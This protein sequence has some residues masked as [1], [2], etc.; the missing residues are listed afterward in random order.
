MAEVL[1]S[2][3]S[4]FA[5]EA[6]AKAGSRPPLVP[7]NGTLFTWLLLPNLLKISDIDICE[8]Y[9]HILGMSCSIGRR[10]VCILQLNM[11]WCT[12]LVLSRC[13]C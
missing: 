6:T 7:L 9:K 13:P 4:D 3:A 1:K 12:F 10:Y 5:T 11:N 8:Q 2:F